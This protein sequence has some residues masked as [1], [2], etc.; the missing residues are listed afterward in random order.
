MMDAG[1]LSPCMKELKRTV[2]KAYPYGFVLRC[3]MKSPYPAASAEDITAILVG[4]KGSPR[5]DFC[6][7]INPDSVSFLMDSF[8]SSSRCPMEYPASISLIMSESPKRAS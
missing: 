7:S 8:F 4:R 5:L 3:F 6:K 1:A 2:L